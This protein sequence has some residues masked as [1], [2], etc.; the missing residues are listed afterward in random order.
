MLLTAPEASSAGVAVTADQPLAPAAVAQL[1]G[2]ARALGARRIERTGHD[3][4]QRPADGGVLGDAGQR[5][6]AAV[7]HDHVQR[8]VDQDDQRAAGFD[9]RAQP[10]HLRV[11][12]ALELDLVLDVADHAG[13]D[14][15]AVLVDP[16][17]RPH[18]D[19]ADLAAG[20]DH[21]EAGE[22]AG[23]VGVE[24]ARG[25]AAHLL[26][27]SG[28][29]CWRKC[30]PTNCSGGTPKKSSAAALAKV[31]FPVSTSSR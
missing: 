31:N 10:G 12:P 1:D 6:E 8:P 25:G 14:Q 24:R 29:M 5:G 2:K 13:A 11:E 3:L 27:R 19:V 9:D 16:A 4:L 21:A 26:D 17:P 20:G 30:V 18:L 7:D 23:V 22:G 15:A 28:A